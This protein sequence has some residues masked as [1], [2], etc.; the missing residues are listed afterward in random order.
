MDQPQHMVEVRGE[1]IPH[2]DATA[3]A[4]PDLM[5]KITLA[6]W[7][8]NSDPAKSCWREID[9]TV[10]N[11]HARQGAAHE[12]IIE[13][14]RAL[15]AAIGEPSAVRAIVQKAGDVLT[16]DWRPHPDSKDIPVSAPKAIAVAKELMT[17]GKV[18][19]AKI[20]LIA[21]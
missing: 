11:H 15:F 10:V 21:S 2:P 16:V 19:L 12:E 7:E 5:V 17:E 8:T 9:H 6:R 4:P 3:G 13:T 1:M 18:M 14:M 20:G